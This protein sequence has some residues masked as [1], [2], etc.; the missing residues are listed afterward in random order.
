MSQQEKYIGYLED[1]VVE[2]GGTLPNESEKE[3]IM[4]GNGRKKALQ[5]VDA[6]EEEKSEVSSDD[7]D[8]E[9]SDG[10]ID[11]ELSAMKKGQTTPDMSLSQM[12]ED[13]MPKFEFDAALPDDEEAPTSLEEMQK[14]LQELDNM[15]GMS[16]PEKDV[17][18]QF[19]DVGIKLQQMNRPETA[20]I[21]IQTDIDMLM[22]YIKDLKPEVCTQGV[23]TLELETIAKEANSCKFKSV[24]TNTEVVTHRSE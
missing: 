24:K 11:E 17:P 10:S 13:S 15:S 18:Q 4:D 23:D 12:T 20:E 7:D 8:D 5:A 19:K 2:L 1:K 14:Q 6:I 3:K 9:L 22:E 21:E 16:S